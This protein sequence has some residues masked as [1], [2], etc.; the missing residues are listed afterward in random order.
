MIQSN[1]TGVQVKLI[2]CPYHWPYD[3]KIPYAYTDYSLHDWP[4][5]PKADPL[6]GLWLFAM[7]YRDN[8]PRLTSQRLHY[9]W[10]P[11][12]W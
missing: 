4:F 6:F 8:F 2:M 3:W 1:D 11:T 5:E 7:T 9:A 12:S 10:A